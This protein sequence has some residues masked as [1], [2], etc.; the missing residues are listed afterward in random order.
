MSGPITRLL[1]VPDPY[2]ERL[3]G[4]RGTV[5]PVVRQRPYNA[6]ELPGRIFK[7]HPG[8]SGNRVDHYYEV[9]ISIQQEAAEKLN[10]R[11][12]NMLPLED[13]VENKRER[14]LEITGPSFHFLNETEVCD[15]YDNT[16]K[17]VTNPQSAIVE[18]IVEDITKQGGGAV[19]A[20]L[21][22]VLKASMTGD[23]IMKIVRTIR[24]DDITVAQKFLQYQRWMVEN[25]QV[26]LGLELKNEK[27][28]DLAEFD[29]LVRRIRSFGVPLVDKEIET[30]RLRLGKKNVEDIL[31]DL[32]ISK[33]RKA[34]VTADFT[35]GQHPNDK[36]FRLAYAHPLG[37]DIGQ[38]ILITT[39]VEKDKIRPDWRATYDASMGERIRLNVFGIVIRTVDK[40]AQ[41]WNITIKPTAIYT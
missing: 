6:A 1:D 30:T 13:P 2:I 7:Q 25:R 21:P 18:K 19:S 4:W 10:E 28:Q 14:L 33:D 34:I 40:D 9:R 38:D 16:F 20:E 11:V 39:M 31:Q 22:Q 36:F 15:F 8:T 37:Q 26:I 3:D 29:D 17:S 41:E 5:T 35:V 23:R 24:F 32:V 27:S 12:I